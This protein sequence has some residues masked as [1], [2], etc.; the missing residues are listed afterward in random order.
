M[1]D[2]MPFLQVLTEVFSG[3]GE[4]AEVYWTFLGLSMPGW[5]FVWYTAFTLGTIVVLLKASRPG[6]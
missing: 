5:T 6:S 4:C 1:L 3:S 2:T